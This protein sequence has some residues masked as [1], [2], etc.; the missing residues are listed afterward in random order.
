MSKFLVQS[1]A[2]ILFVAVAPVA[3]AQTQPA[4]AP[5]SAPAQDQLLQPGEIDAL[6]SP[7]ALYPDALM[8]QVLMAATYPLEVIQASRWLKENKGLKDDALRAALDKQ[9]WDESVK[10]LAA[11]PSVLDMMAD[12]LDW[13]QKLGDAMLAQQNDVMDGVQRLRAKA[14]ANNKLQSTPQQKVSKRSEGGKQ[15]IVIEPTNPETMYVPYYDPA[16]VY[17]AWPYPA[18]PPYYWGASYWPYGGA[19]L[20][21]GLAFGAGYAVGRWAGWAGGGGYWGGNANINWNNNNININRPG[22]GGNWNH[23]P[24][25]RQGVRY[26]NKGVADRMGRGNNNRAGAGNRADFR[27]RDGAG[28]NRPGGG[29]GAGNRPG[30]GAGAGNRPG[31]G[32]KGAGGRPGGGQKAA[33]RPSGGGGA[34]P[35]GGGGGGRSAFAGSGG[36]GRAAQA[37]ASR[38]RASM[39]GGGGGGGRGGGGGARAG[40][41]GGGGRGGGGGGRGGGGGGGGGGGRRSDIALKHDIMLLGHLDNG[42]GFYRFSYNGSDKAYVGVMAQE[43]QAVAPGAVTRGHDGYLRVFYD[44][45]GLQFQ[46]YDQWLATGARIPSAAPLH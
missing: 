30:G 17:G 1:L 31:G 6:L 16:V 7:I 35:G 2:F 25:H 36:G 9:G 34:R 39:G 46:T 32:Q 18:Y 42:L 15:V 37:S 5:A 4:P 33:Q 40:G 8:A 24:E 23:R 45:L 21:A 10:S 44:R 29:A 19:I 12:K 22:G 14:E 28:G 3:N 11:T 13:T 20:G 38:G 26:N 27:G 43:V 41:G